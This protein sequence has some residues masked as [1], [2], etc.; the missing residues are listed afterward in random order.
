MFQSEARRRGI[1]FKTE[2]YAGISAG[3]ITATAASGSLSIK[4]VAKLA[5]YFWTNVLQEAHHVL[6]EPVQYY[7]V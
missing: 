1:L 6:G 5:D 4:D 2:A 7:T 3:L